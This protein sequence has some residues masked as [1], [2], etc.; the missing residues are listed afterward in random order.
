MWLRTAVWMI[1]TV[2]TGLVFAESPRRPGASAK[3]TGVSTY[4]NA[5][6]KVSVHNR[7]WSGNQDKISYLDNL[8]VEQGALSPPSSQWAFDEKTATTSAQSMLGV[9]QGTLGSTV[10]RVE[11]V[12]GQAAS[13]P[14]SSAN[15]QVDFTSSVG[16]F[17]SADYSLSFWVN[18]T[19]TPTTV[20]ELLTNRATDACAAS[21]GSRSKLHRIRSLRSLA[22]QHGAN[23]LVAHTQYLDPSPLRAPSRHLR[24]LHQRPTRDHHDAHRRQRRQRPTPPLRPQQRPNF[25]CPLRWPGRRRPHLQQSPQRLRSLGPIRPLAGNAVARRR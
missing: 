19:A 17:G 1:A 4:V 6:N 3:T 24:H 23:D 14:G 2:F 22:L 16:Q 20:V 21:I 12:L 11:G 10:T 25:H 9:A 18:P 13:L 5:S 8:T 7:E 15:S